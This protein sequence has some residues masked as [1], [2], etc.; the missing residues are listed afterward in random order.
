[1]WTSVKPVMSLSSSNL[2][3]AC[4]RAADVRDDANAVIFRR[5]DIRVQIAQAFAVVIS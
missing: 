5:D 4:S 1:M 3:V 2:P